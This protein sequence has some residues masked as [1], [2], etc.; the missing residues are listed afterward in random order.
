MSPAEVQSAPEPALEVETRYRRNRPAR[1]A[2]HS[3]RAAGLTSLT[4]DSYRPSAGAGVVTATDR[5][6]DLW[7]CLTASEVTRG[8]QRQAGSQRNRDTTT[9]I[10]SLAWV[11]KQTNRLTHD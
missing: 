8:S 7:P 10:C 3:G 1:R 2:H 9:G 11:V 6:G 5:C 4:S